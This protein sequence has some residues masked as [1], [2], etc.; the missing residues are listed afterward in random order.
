MKHLFFALTV[1]ILSQKSFSQTKCEIADSYGEFIK[2][3]KYMDN[4][5]EYLVK[6][7]VEIESK[8][9]FA[10]VVNNN[11]SYIQYLLTNF[12]S[13]SNYENL[14]K[15]PDSL[16]LQNEY[17]NSL[18]FDTLFNSAM[19]D[20]ISKTIE[21]PSLKDSIQI[22]KLLNIAVKYFSIRRINEAGNYIGKVCAGLNDINKTEKER[23]PQL[24]AFCFSSIMDNYQGKEFNMYEEFVKAIKELYK[25]NL[26]TDNSERLLRAQ[27]GMFILMRN[28]E[29]L[30]KMLINEYENKMKYLPFILIY[31]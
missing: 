19:S 18:K 22:D 2:I 7:V 11:I 17:I 1:L 15:I 6:L 8:N 16:T 31:N 29:N 12:S 20:L 21:Q 27:G 10:D 28:N 30:K 25:V 4:D 13:N 9:C 24:E 3:E 26:G 14:L 5:M 23:Q